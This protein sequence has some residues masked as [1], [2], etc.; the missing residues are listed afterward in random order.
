MTTG[1]NAGPGDA[2][3][4]VADFYPKLGEY[5]AERHAGGYDAVA[6]R[7]HFVIW[8]AEHADKSAARPP[9]ADRGGAGGLPAAALSPGDVM[10]RASLMD[11]I[12]EA[13]Q[14]PEPGDREIAGLGARIRAGRDA[15][16]ALAG[17]GALTAHERAALEWAADRGQRAR[18]RLAE[19]HLRLVVSIAKRYAGRGLPFLDLVQEGSLGLVRAAEKFE[20][21]KGYAFPAYATWW[22]RQAMTRAVARQ[23]G[24]AWVPA[25]L[26]EAIGEIVVVQRRL[27]R[28]L[29]RQPTPEELAAELGTRPD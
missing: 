21:D 13:G 9:H 26:A 2:E 29:G 7:A 20:D 1:S 8:L 6:G 18:D 28:E 12:A 23:A 14:V 4:F 15:E 19:A 27:S 24:T 22:I 25:G 11:Y 16:E 17:G 5:L 10:A 3:L